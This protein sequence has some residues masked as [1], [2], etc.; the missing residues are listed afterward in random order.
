LLVSSVLLGS[1]RQVIMAAKAMTALWIA[2]K[3]LEDGAKCR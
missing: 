1:K 2:T 3:R